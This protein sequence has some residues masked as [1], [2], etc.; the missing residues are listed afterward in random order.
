MYT[1]HSSRLGMELDHRSKD[2][3]SRTVGLLLQRGWRHF[4]FIRAAR[5]LCAQV[6]L[7]EKD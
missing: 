5:S 6:Q 7:I 3:T 2:Y 4:R 1:E